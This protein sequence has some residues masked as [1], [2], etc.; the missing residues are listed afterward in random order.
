[1]KYK[2]I[3]LMIKLWCIISCITSCDI[4]YP[5]LVDG[6]PEKQLS[7]DGNSVVLRGASSFSDVVVMDLDGNFTVQ[8]D[9]LNIKHP[10]NFVKD[11]RM[12]F[13]CNDSLIE[14]QKSFQMSG[15][16]KLSIK[17]IADYPLHF[18]V[19]GA[20]ELL[21]SDFILCGGNPLITDTVRFE[22]KKNRRRK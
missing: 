2:S 16:N 18:G 5:L 20:I 19:I 6:N 22:N 17:L 7:C 21:P 1:M 11:F 14:K 13:Y 8:L 4:V 12:F 10:R 9:S 3:V 15:K